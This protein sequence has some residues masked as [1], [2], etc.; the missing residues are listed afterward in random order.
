ML[1]KSDIINGSDLSGNSTL[2]SSWLPLG[3]ENCSSDMT[4]PLFSHCHCP[5]LN[6]ETIPNEE[7]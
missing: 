5:F 1:I 3:A 2:S 7:L 4:L 6:S